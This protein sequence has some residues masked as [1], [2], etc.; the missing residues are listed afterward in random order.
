MNQ[1]TVTREDIAV[2]QGSVKFPQYE[3]ILESAKRLNDKLVKV[4]VDDENIQL[5]KKLVAEVRKEANRL[6]SIRKEIKKEINQ[7]YQDFED[8]V[9]EIILTV[10]EGEDIIREQT[11][12]FDEKQR[13]EKQDE[14]RKILHLRLKAYK[15]VSKLNIDEE[16]IIT[17]K[18][19]NKSTSINKAEQQMV[20]KLEEIKSSLI[21]FENMEHTNELIEAYT[22]TLDV[23]HA[24]KTV[25]DRHKRIEEIRQTEKQQKITDNIEHTIKLFN[26]SD[27]I[28]VTKFLN[29]NNIKYN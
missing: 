21:N 26:D 20:D 6:D 27:Y 24:I 13:Q 19:L 10:K 2:T 12:A 23:N 9:K 7:P 28:K 11:R 4:E 15:R 22:L 3:N 17:P 8:K 14:L 25:N 1:L 18:M 16:L 29:E 5:N